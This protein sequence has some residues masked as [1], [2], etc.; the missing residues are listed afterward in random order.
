MK[1]GILTGGGDCSGL[2]AVIRA[3]VKSALPRGHEV[4]GIYDGWE[5]LVNLAGRQLHP[6]DASG[7]LFSGGTILNTSRFD[8]FADDPDGNKVRAGFEALE[9]DALICVGGNG[10]LGIAND[11][12]QIG[13]PIVGIP[14]TIDN[15]VAGTDYA[16][17]FDTAVHV[18]ANSLDMLHSTAA[19][20]HRC[21]IVEVMGRHSGWLAMVGGLTG[22]ADCILIPEV[23][24]DIEQLAIMLQKRHHTKRFSI[25]VVAEGIKPPPGVKDFRDEMERSSKRKALEGISHIIAGEIRQ[26]IDIETKVTVLGYLQRAGTPSPF[27]RQLGTMFGLKAVQMVQDREFG[28]CV[29]FRGGKYDSVSLHHASKAPRKLDFDIYNAAEIFFG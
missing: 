1:I 2:N 4:F 19:S 29:V 21:M 18:V 5:G 14:K 25:V 20:H 22:G 12:F 7:I 15:D 3:V 9:L 6:K 28:K 27:D 16:V 13:L 10:T 24:Y 26:R 8:P 23:P 11:A 17:G